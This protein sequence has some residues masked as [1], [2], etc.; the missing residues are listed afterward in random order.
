MYTRCYKNPSNNIRV[1]ASLDHTLYRRR[2][3]YSDKC[4]YPF[5]SYLPLDHIMIKGE[6]YIFSPFL[7][8]SGVAWFLGDADLL[9]SSD[10]PARLHPIP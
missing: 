8:T 2:V 3:K 6:V 5:F 4:H 10:P 1:M 7:R 9:P